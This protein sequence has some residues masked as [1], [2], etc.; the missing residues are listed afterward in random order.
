MEAG[1]DLSR[2]SRLLGHTTVEITHRYYARWTEDEL[3]EL[4]ARVSYVADVEE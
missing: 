2:V 4:H 3:A 1:G